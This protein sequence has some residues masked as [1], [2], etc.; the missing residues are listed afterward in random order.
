MHRT[1]NKGK[2]R[3]KRH[4]HPQTLALAAL[5]A[6]VTTGYESV[7]FSKKRPQPRELSWLPI[8]NFAF[9]ANMIGTHS[10]SVLNQESAEQKGAIVRITHYCMEQ[11]GF[12]QQNSQQTPI[13][14]SLLAT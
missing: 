12:S 10:A 2:Q 14:F 11:I 8:V 13:P 7:E 3:S 9:R 1:H 6:K 5:Y 4:L